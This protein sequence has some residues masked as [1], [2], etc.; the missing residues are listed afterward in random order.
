MLSTAEVAIAITVVCIAQLRPLYR[1]L[2]GNWSTLDESTKPTV[3]TPTY[4]AGSKPTPRRNVTE[5]TDIV[6]TRLPVCETRITGGKMVGRR[7]DGTV[8]PPV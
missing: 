6:E 5:L 2:R 3:V 1:K 8:I 7:E 4:G